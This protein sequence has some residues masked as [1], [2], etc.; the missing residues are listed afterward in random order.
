MRSKK[1]ERDRV[2]V[3]V[4]RSAWG[5]RQASSKDAPEKDKGMNGEL[6]E[7]LAT[8]ERELREY[9]LNSG[10]GFWAES[11]FS[12]HTHLWACVKRKVSQEI[13]PG[14]RGGGREPT[15]L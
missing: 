7:R 12:S 11:S 4:V 13:F 10:E 1:K 5:R 15:R 6:E 3:Q 2:Q 14:N 9:P 8:Y